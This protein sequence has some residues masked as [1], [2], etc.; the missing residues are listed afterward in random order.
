MGLH[1]DISLLLQLQQFLG[2]IGSIYKN[3]IK[4]MV[5]YI[6]S[7]KKDLISLIIHLEKYPLLT[8][9]GADFLLFKKV[10]KLMNEKAHLSNEGLYQIVNFKASINLG[11]SDFFKSEFKDFIPI[12]KSVI[13]TENIPDPNW[14]SGFVTGEG[15]FDVRITEYSK[16]KI[17]YRVQLRFRIS[18]HER[19]TELLTYLIKYLDSGKL[20]KYPNK[21]AI[22]YIVFYFSD[23]TN[24]IIPFFENN[25]L[26]GIKLFDYLDWCKIAKLM[27]EGSHLTLEG[28]Y[29]I[30]KIKSGMNKGRNINDI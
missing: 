9:K 29:F 1:R 5:N 15:N 23:I 2:G 8:Q 16:N 4:N 14:I 6:I 28:F 26:L 12:E 25:P 17:G 20:Y 7:S 30:N 3:P 19:D 21:P 18:Q 13:K 24:I 22:V 10:I 27:N 11:L